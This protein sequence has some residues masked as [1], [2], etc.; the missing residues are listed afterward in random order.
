MRALDKREI[1]RNAESGITSD[2]KFH[3]GQCVMSSQSV[4][5]LK[6]PKKIVETNLGV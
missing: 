1:E 5:L 2:R 6:E 4:E 3:L